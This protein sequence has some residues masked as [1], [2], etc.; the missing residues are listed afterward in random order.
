[1]NVGMHTQPGAPPSFTAV[2]TRAGPA[3]RST[4]GGLLLGFYFVWSALAG[5]AVGAGEMTSCTWS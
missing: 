2:E 1:M 4:L 5:Y 3:R